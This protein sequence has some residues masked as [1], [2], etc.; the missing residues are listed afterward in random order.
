MHSSKTPDFSATSLKPLTSL[1]A[2]HSLSLTSTF[3]PWTSLHSQ[4][5]K[6]YP[7]Q[8]SPNPITTCSEQFSFELTQLPLFPSLYRGCAPKH[9]KGLIL[10]IL[11]TWNSSPN[12][13][14][15][16]HSWLLSG[17]PKEQLVSLTITQ[18]N[19]L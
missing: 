13:S 5:R 9:L 14:V 19:T 7:V 17:T 6:A 1:T 16:S 3:V 8:V 10:V 12:S 18:V 2:F 4:M 11:E 15:I